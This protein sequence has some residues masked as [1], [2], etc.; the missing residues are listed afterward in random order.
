M[1]TNKNKKNNRHLL[2]LALCANIILFALEL[3]ITNLDQAKKPA[4]I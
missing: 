2:E 1:Y 3:T 4:P